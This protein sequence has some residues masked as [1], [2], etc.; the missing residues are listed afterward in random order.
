MIEPRHLSL[1]RELRDRGSVAAVAQ[2]WHLTPSAVS[3]QIR[4]AEK[5]LGMRLVEASGRGLRLTDA[6]SLVA[7]QA[8]PVQAALERAATAVADFRGAPR[9]SLRLAALPSVAEY[10][11]PRM[12]GAAAQEGIEV[13]VDDLDVA[14]A[15]FADLATDY[16]LVLG[17]ALGSAPRT[18][19]TLTVRG[20]LRE[21]LDVAVGPGHRWW[22][23][24]TV[25]PGEAAG[26]SWIAP[27]PGYPFR[28]LLDAL[29]ERAGEEIRVVQ[30][31]RDNRLVES[32][33]VAGLGV[34]LLPR[35]TTRPRTDL[36]LLELREVDS[37]RQVLLM[38]RPDRA[39]RAVVRRVTELLTEAARRP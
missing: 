9:G 15:D 17:H 14:E 23:R 35:Y 21:P 24:R 22:R 4:S 8:L 13:A 19:R 30:E 28:L 36:R 16:D 20:L 33:V 6:G 7:E 25:R 11:L 12:L 5:D 10:L 39:E 27:P 18:T 2:A 37:A 3:Q 26:E 31:L 32:L 34:A 1:M 38:A 29:Q